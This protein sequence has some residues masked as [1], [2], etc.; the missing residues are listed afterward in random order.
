MATAK[1]Q[2]AKRADTKPLGR[3]TA[4]TKRGKNKVP[5]H[6]EKKKSQT[7]NIVHRKDGK[8]DGAIKLISYEKNSDGTATLRAGKATLDLL[9]GKDDVR[10]WS[11][12]E[13]LQGHRDN[14]RR[15]PNMVPMAVYQELANRVMSKA[16]FYWVAELEVAMTKCF[17]IVKNIDATDK[18]R[19]VTMVEWLAIKE[20]F[21]R[22]MGSPE[23]KV[24]I[25][26]EPESWKSAIANALVPSAST[27]IEVN[28]EDPGDDDPIDAAV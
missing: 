18:D 3:R 22:V 10:E 5:I 4:V 8:N 1:K 11:D 12:K 2:S 7:G 21:E 19:K 27:T 26:L 6:G 17:E 14:V 15:P 28:A 9:E 23:Q 25:G 24:T 13:L 16:R 20:I